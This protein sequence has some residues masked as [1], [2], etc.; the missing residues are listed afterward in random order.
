MAGVIADVRRREAHQAE[1][2]QR[3]DERRARREDSQHPWRQAR[4]D[5]VHMDDLGAMFR[6]QSPNLGDART[7]P[8][9]VGGKREAAPP[10]VDSGL[11]DTHV[12]TPVGQQ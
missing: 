9:D 7:G 11:E 4:Y 5:A 10:Q 1:V 6:D 12:V 3:H 8:H 2:V